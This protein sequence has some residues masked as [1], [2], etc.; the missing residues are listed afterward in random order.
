MPSKKKPF[1]GQNTLQSR[2]MKRSRAMETPYDRESRLNA[3]CSRS[4]EW[5]ACSDPNIRE[6]RL[7]ADRLRKNESRATESA[8]NRENILNK[9]R[10]R[11]QV[12][13]RALGVDLKLAVFNY[14]K[15]CDYR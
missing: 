9:Q 7:E 1:I 6:I 15:E 2:K 8:I 10:K 12:S 11:D 4:K 5:R 13:K 3:N 14:N